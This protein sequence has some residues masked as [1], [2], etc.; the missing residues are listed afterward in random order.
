[1]CDSARRGARA[2]ARAG[3]VNLQSEPYAIEHVP[4]LRFLDDSFSVEDL[5]PFPAPLQAHKRPVVV[6]VIVVDKN[7]ADAL[8][9]VDELDVPVVNETAALDHAR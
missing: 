4:A 2:C 9:R 8:G 5:Q 7:L 1:M 6:T 3:K